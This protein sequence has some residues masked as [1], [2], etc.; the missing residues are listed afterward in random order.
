MDDK[1]INVVVG[2]I[3]DSNHRILLAR[4]ANDAHQGGKWEFPGGK[5]EPGE[6]N[7]A[8][9]SRE[10]KEELDINVN[11]AR[12]FL[13][14]R[15]AYNDKKIAFYTWLVK[16]WS[17]TPRGRQGQPLT[18]VSF[19]DLS[20]E[21]M[22][23][24]NANII[25]ALHLPDFYLICPEPNVDISIYL[26]VLESC[27]QEGVRL[28]QLRMRET[29]YQEQPDF[30]PSIKKLCEKYKTSIF[31]NS[32]PMDAIA[33]QVDGVHL[34]SIRLLQINEPI[35]NQDLRVSASCH[36]K[37][38][39]EQAMRINAEFI[40]LSPVNHTNSHPDA[41]PL[42]W[43]KFTDLVS[44][45]NIPVFALGGMTPED[46]DKSWNSGA[47]GLATLGGIWLSPDPMASIRAFR[48]VSG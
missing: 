40:V 33:W 47:H 48:N 42:G 26:E 19:E 5:Q 9:L 23:L 43:K 6:T 16:S 8:A 21:N 28:L 15:Y 45:S 10:L 30:I 2:V 14:F 3:I 17:G 1:E 35:N 27:L 39:I 24:A 13:N 7:Y 22:P 36:N 12:P 18:W 11:D 29:Y 25:N 38:E 37:I 20:P 4:R 44:Y 32:S 41:E 31:L 34:N 46:M